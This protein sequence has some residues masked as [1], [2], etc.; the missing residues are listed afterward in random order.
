MRIFLAGASG[1]VGKR[2]VPALVTKGHQV[3]GMVHSPQ[4]ADWV[5]SMGAEPIVA[6]GLD[7]DAVRQAV[8][9]ARPQVIVNQMTSLSTDFNAR[10]FDQIFSITNRLRT[11]G[12]DNLLAAAKASGV[13]R[14]IA[15]S[16]AGWPYARIGGPVKTE[17]DPLDPNPP[18]PM[19]D[20]LTAI[21]HLESATTES[22]LE[23]IVLRY[24]SF[25]GPGTTSDGMLGQ[26]RKRR[27]PVVGDGGAIWSF[28]HID[29][30]AHATVAAVE[31][32]APGIYNIV[33]DEPATVASWLPELARLTGSQ[34]P[35][36]VPMWL[37]RFLIGEAGVVMMTATR[38]ASNQKAKMELGWTPFWKS[39]RDG[40][41]HEIDEH[42]QPKAA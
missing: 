11:E 8:A 26:I 18:K 30:A 15:Q 33:D 10:K 4:K 16:Y 17:T 13:R 37:A 24:G 19:R 41:R 35:R 38:G 22:G 27:M 34:P 5:R 23:G 2:L 7:A 32:G 1:A 29:D 25:Y 20:T 21:R 31:G 36:R 39:W 9:R 28:M 40:F 6:N 14:F 3:V 12:N 42:R